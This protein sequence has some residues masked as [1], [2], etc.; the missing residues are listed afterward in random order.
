MKKI[1]ILTILFFLLPFVVFAEGDLASDKFFKAE[2]LEILEQ[3]E[4]TLPDGEIVIQQNLKL[5][6]KDGEYKEKTVEFI[7]IDDFTTL[8]SNLYKKGDIVMVVA[9]QNEEGQENYYITEYVRSGIVWWLFAIFVFILFLVGR[10]KGLR[11]LL[12]LAL[13]FFVIIKYIIPSILSGGNILP[14]TIIGSV[15]IL[16]FV[17]YITEGFNKRSH[18]SMLSSLFVLALVMFFS[19]LFVYLAKLSGVAS[20]EVAYL[21]NIGEGLVNFKGLLLSGIIIGTLGV[22]DDVIISQVASVE[23]IYKTDPKQS[24]NEVF[25]KAYQIGVSHISSMTNTLFLA[26]AGASLPLLVLFVSGDSAFSS[27][28]DII[29]NEAIATEIIRTLSGSIGIILAVPVTTILA[30]WMFRSKSLA[31][32]N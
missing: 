2:V 8:K 13:T 23:Q 19:F 25:K 15:L 27:W 3:R 21:V 12:S 10:W 14:V 11:S 26:Y 24:P 4:N 9:S 28:N 32:N 29:N 31:K 22:M 17:I 1:I 5:K 30:S 20:E 6:G 16:T 18:V 7:G